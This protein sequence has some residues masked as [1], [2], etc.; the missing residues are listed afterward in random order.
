MFFFK[1]K[2]KVFIFLNVNEFC[3]KYIPRY[4]I[5]WINFIK[6]NYLHFKLL[7]K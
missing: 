6:F 5:N 1:L 3:I 2:S 4:N 7:K